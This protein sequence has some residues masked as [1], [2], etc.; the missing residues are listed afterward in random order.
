MAG[1]QSKQKTH[2]NLRISHIHGTSRE[3]PGPDAGSD[4]G[5][6]T[7]GGGSKR[8]HGGN[9]VLRS[10]E[11]VHAVGVE[12]NECEL[13][14]I[15]NNIQRMMCRNMAISLSLSFTSS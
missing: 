1:K 2:E 10:L 12:R 6:G 11:A 7:A 5:G 15:T 9:S 3:G 13:K 4:E 14:N 8:E